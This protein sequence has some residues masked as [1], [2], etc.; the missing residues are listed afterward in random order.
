MCDQR[1]GAVTSTVTP[2][3]LVEG[4][5]KTS[6]QWANGWPVLLTSVWAAYH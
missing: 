4:G 2:R 5:F 3:L 1:Q 6:A